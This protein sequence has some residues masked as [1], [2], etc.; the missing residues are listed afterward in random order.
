MRRRWL[1]RAREGEGEVVKAGVAKA[2]F[3]RSLL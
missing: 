3:G 2:E 1:N